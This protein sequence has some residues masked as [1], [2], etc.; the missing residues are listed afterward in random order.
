MKFLAEI[1][2]M[3]HKEILDPQGKAISNN[4]KRVDV[5]GIEDVRI[6]KHVKLWVEAASEHEAKELVE[7][8]CRKMLVNHIMEGY[9]YTLVAN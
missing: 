1:D 5:Y 7:A 6:G 3:P 2:I 8:A 4:L 9:T